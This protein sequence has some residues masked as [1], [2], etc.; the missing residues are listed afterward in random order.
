MRRLEALKGTSYR[1]IRIIPVTITQRTS[2]TKRRR[3]RIPTSEVHD[4]SDVLWWKHG[5]VSGVGDTRNHVKK[6]CDIGHSLHQPFVGVSGHF[7]ESAQAAT[8]IL[9][10]SIT[11]ITSRA[12]KKRL[13]SGLSTIGSTR[14]IASCAESFTVR[15]ARSR[16]WFVMQM[17]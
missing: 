17:A 3:N 9:L 7:R 13:I 5:Q 15:T 1:A 14:I 16:V 10:P 12:T 6:C 8:K 2:R 11:R 4:H